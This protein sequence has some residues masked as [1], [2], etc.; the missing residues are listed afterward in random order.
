MKVL[1]VDLDRT[2]QPNLALMKLSA[3]HKDRGH[4]VWLNFTLQRYDLC[5]CSCVFT[6]NA[7]K[8]GS[9]PY[10]DIELGGSGF[11][12]WNTLPDE[13]E[14]IMPD[15]ALYGYPYSLG[16]TSRGC[17]KHCPWCIVARKEGPI[18]EWTEIVDNYYLE[19]N[20]KVEI[21]FTCEAHWEGKTLVIECP[22]FAARDFM[23]RTL[24]EKPIIVKVKEK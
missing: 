20:M 17:I 12:L 23:A 21:K 2:R 16:F 4:E 15:Y 19:A 13:I 3:W 14:H 5:Y 7:P 11:N 18:R 1:L 24:E 6:W 9:F 10:P 22:S 8:L